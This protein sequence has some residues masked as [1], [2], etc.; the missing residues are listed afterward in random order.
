LIQ[1]NIGQLVV[2]RG[3]AASP[4]Y[5]FALDPVTGMYSPNNTQLG[6]S[7]GGTNIVTMDGTGGVGNY[8]TTFVG[9]VQANLISGGA[10]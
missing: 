3:T 2:N 8:I 9:R 7:V 5:T 1:S 4:A 10:F 6:F